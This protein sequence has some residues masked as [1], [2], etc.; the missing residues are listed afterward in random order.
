MVS[1]TGEI[2]IMQVKRLTV[3]QK[4][5]IFKALVELQDLQQVTVVDSIKRV[6]EQFGITEKELRKIQDEGIEREWP[7]LE[8]AV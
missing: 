7:P 8:Q 3:K 4:K 2:G 1:F 6:A 5:E